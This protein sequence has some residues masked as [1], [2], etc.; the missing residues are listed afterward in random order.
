MG[1]AKATRDESARNACST[2]GGDTV[3]IVEDPTHADLGLWRELFTGIDYV[4][5]KATPAYYGIGV[6]RG[7]RSAVVLVPG[8]LGFDAYLFEMYWWLQRI[9]YKPYFSRIGHN[10]ECP[11]VLT[12]RL[13]RTVNRAYK[14]TGRPVHLVGHSLGGVLSRGVASLAPSRVASVT[15]L[16]SPFRGVRVNPWVMWSLMFVRKRIMARR[17]SRGDCFTAACACGFT[18]AM[19]EDFPAHVQQTAIYTKTD[20]VVDWETCITGDPEID[21]EVKGT[22][23][24]LAWNGA[25]YRLVAQRLAEAARASRTAARAAKKRSAR[26]SQA[27]RQ[28]DEK[29]IRPGTPV[30]AH[31]LRGSRLSRTGQTVH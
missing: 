8:F 29:D 26:A 20:G 31:A 4:G 5:L 16:G 14:E 24:G 30:P 12:N 11:D 6:P 10:A 7:D 3:A 25:V 23:V 1:R 21:F 13:L 28:R 18:C 2:S 22:H 17:R 27:A 9:G 19:R 15:M